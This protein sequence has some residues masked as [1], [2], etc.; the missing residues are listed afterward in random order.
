MT[1]ERYT[2][3]AAAEWD[4]FVD[5]SRNGT[6]LHRRAYMDY[7]A[8][9]F[10]DR[11]LMVR[12]AS[13]R[14]LAVLPAHVDATGTVLA[15]HNGLSY[16]GWLVAPRRVTAA[17]MLDIFGLLVA[18][19]RAEGLTELIYRP[20]P[21]IYH[22]QPAEEDLY[23]LWR[24]GATVIATG[25]SSTIDLQAPSLLDRNSHN[26]IN[27]A[28]RS[29]V[30]I[31][32][33][34]AWAEFWGLLTA[35][36]E[37][38][39]EVKP[40]HSLDEMNLLRSRFPENIRLYAAT[41]AGSLLAGMVV[42]CTGRVVHSQYIA[43]GEEARRERLLPALYH[44]VITAAA[45]SGARYFDFGISTEQG[46]LVLNDNLD[47]HKSQAGGRTTITQAFRLVLD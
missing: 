30:L 16:G 46:G 15:S 24:M 19:M 8:S 37:A 10:P 20:V 33:S 47:I 18:R 43:A 13:G 14:L 11:S 40:V 34:E 35:V 21:H 44:H 36:L 9:R 7:H 27:R 22:R 25:A 42:Y 41:R 6:F 12:D 5:A 17:V 45:A 39:H 31:A 29:D 23:A 2:P 32:P 3:A 38:R 26:A 1:I 4:A 28:A